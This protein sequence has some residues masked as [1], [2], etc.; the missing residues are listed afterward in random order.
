MTK[1]EQKN[2]YL[3]DTYVSLWLWGQIIAFIG[4]SNMCV[5]IYSI[6]SFLENKD[7]SMFF[8]PCIIIT[9]IFAYFSV[10]LKNARRIIFAQLKNNLQKN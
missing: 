6:N 4:I 10:K 2:K 9:L 5:V 7:I 3:N 1:F 8:I